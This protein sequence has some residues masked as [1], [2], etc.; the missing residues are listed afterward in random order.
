MS[1]ISGKDDLLKYTQSEKREP[2]DESFYNLWQGKN[3][4]VNATKAVKTLAEQ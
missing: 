4:E 1:I 3:V 2:Q